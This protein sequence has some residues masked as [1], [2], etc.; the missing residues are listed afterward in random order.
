MNLGRLGPIPVWSGCFSL[1]SGVSSFGLVGAGCF[2]P[3]LKVG[4]F[5]SSF[6]VSR[7][8]LIYLLWENR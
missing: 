6:G 1:I 5:G 7:F 2:G 4:P 8:G 3:I